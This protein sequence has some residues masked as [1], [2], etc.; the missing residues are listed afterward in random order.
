MQTQVRMS[1]GRRHALLVLLAA[2]AILWLG[3]SSAKAQESS[4][5]PF[6]NNSTCYG[7]HQQSGLSVEVPSGEILYLDVFEGEYENSVHGSFGVSCRN[8]HTDIQGFPHPELTARSLADFTDEL[9]GSCEICHRDHYTK[10]ADEIHTGSAALACSN[11][12]DPH[13]T[14]TGDV[15]AEVRLNCNECHVEG[16]A[17]PAEGIHAFPELPERNES[18]SGLTIL[19]ILGGAIVGFVVLV[20]LATVAW[21]VIREKA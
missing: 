12:H 9:A 1:A 10:V 19:L 16:V 5:D 6:W 4:S 20:W 3:Q 17:I 18:I 2:T 21:R 13:T 14:G 8:C 11:C 7:C 15:S